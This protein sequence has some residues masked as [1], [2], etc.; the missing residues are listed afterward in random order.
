MKKAL[1]I[2]AE[3]HPMLMKNK[4]S[5]FSVF[6]DDEHVGCQMMGYTQDIVLCISALMQDAVANIGEEN[7]ISA[8]MS[9]LRLAKVDMYKL[10]FAANYTKL[11]GAAYEEGDEQ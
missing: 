11:Y 3:I 7:T 10:I 6:A 2:L 5:G 9:G 8:V 1:E 4:I